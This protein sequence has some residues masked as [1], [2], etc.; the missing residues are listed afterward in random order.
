MGNIQTASVDTQADGLEVEVVGDVNGKIT[1]L[2][3]CHIY[4]NPFAAKAL[5]EVAALMGSGS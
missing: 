5:A 2:A 1:P 3:R 4:S